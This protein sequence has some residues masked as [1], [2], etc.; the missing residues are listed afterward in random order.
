MQPTFG[1]GVLSKGDDMSNRPTYREEVEGKQPERDADCLDLPAVARVFGVLALIGIVMMLIGLLA[2]AAGCAELSPSTCKV[3]EFA[4]QAES[5]GYGSGVLIAK[6]DGVGYVLTAAH[7]VSCVNRHVCV[8]PKSDAFTYTVQDAHFPPDDQVDLC[9]LEIAA[10]VDI[11]PRS[12]CWQ[13]LEV[14]D[15]VWQSGYGNRDQ[16][17]PREYWSNV[18]PRVEYTSEGKAEFTDPSLL[19]LSRPSRQGDSGG[20]VIDAN[21]RVVGITSSTDKQRGY[22]VTLADQDWLKALLPLTEHSIV[23]NR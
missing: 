11:A 15:K 23:V 14:G 17:G 22:H 4:P 8:F 12:I 20:P 9:L 13:P 2:S 18:L 19:L 16:G 1:W 5:K 7:V 6:A 3:M 10:P 21:A